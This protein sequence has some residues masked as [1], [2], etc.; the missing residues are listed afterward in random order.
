M[1]GFRRGRGGCAPPLQFAKHGLSGV[2]LGGFWL[3]F[4][5]NFTTEDIYIAPTLE[6]YLKFNL[7][8]FLC[9][10]PLAEISTVRPTNLKSR[11]RPLLVL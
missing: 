4:L 6:K 5:A 10:A 11:I 2:D 1:G 9:L 3:K 8:S 7:K